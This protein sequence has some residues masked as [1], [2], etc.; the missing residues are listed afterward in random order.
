MQKLYNHHLKPHFIARNDLI[1][2][3]LL[4]LKETITPLFEQE[5]EIDKKVAEIQSLALK[6]QAVDLLS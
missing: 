4:L 6:R 3:E 1:K 5:G 2:Q